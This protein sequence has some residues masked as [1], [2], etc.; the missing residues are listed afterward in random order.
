MELETTSP[1]FWPEFAL[2]QNHEQEHGYM[3]EV[4]IVYPE[5]LHDSHD[6]FPLAP[7]HLYIQK[8]MLSSYQKDL[9]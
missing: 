5:E 6:N 8:D 2:N 3:F 7:E 1:K 4:D 9:A